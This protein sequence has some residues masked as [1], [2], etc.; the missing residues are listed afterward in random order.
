GSLEK[1]R[2]RV[3]E[4]ITVF[5]GTTIKSE[6]KATIDQLPAYWFD[7][8]FPAQGGEM[9]GRLYL[10]SRNQ[11]F[12]RIICLSSQKNFER[13]LPTFE[14]IVQSFTFVTERESGS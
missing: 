7:Y 6:G 9:Q 14:H 4:D 8:H 3:R 12:Y 1:F 2:K 13:Y 5:P 10:F 11:G